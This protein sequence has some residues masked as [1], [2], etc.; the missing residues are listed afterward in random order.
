[1]QTKRLQIKL[2]EKQY[3][4]LERIAKENYYSKSEII[5]KLVDLLDDYQGEN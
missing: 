3:N 2:T 1:M 5:R 4:L